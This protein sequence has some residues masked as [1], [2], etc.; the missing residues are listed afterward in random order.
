MRITHSGYLVVP[1]RINQSARVGY[2]A[3]M[4]KLPDRPPC[5]KCGMY[6][7]ATSKPATKQTFEC[8]RCGHAETRRPEAT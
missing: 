3:H 7:I 2:A 8:L 1:L 4:P 5:P 6:M